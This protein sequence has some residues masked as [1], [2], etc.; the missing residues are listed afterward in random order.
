[1]LTMFISNTPGLLVVLLAL[2]LSTKVTRAMD[3]QPR[4]VKNTKFSILLEK[5]QPT[6]DGSNFETIPDSRNLGMLE[7]LLGK[8]M[9]ILREPAKKYQKNKGKTYHG[10]RLI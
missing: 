8:I 5:L 3:G 2:V 1:M 9:K 10:L 6:K 7:G 4:L